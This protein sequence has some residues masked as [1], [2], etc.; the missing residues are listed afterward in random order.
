MN[1]SKI[2]FS[3]LFFSFITILMLY[4]FVKLTRQVEKDIANIKNEINYLNDKIKVNELEFVAHSSPGYLKKLEQLY[5]MNNYN[6]NAELNIISI[7]D[8]K[9]KNIRKVFR[10]S[11]N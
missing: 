9:I 4:H 1:Y 2:G 11:K 7:Q 10:V 8:Y 6:E 3:L 5:L